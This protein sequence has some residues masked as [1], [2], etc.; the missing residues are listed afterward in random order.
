MRGKVISSASVLF[1]VLSTIL[2]LP[3]IYSGIGIA[4]ADS[5]IAT[6]P[7]GGDGIA[8]D[9]ANGNLYVTNY[10]SDTVSVVS[11]QTNTVIKCYQK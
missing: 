3:A 8:F 9:S 7:V 10:F 1:L 5:V 11:G 4:K 2:S 6:I